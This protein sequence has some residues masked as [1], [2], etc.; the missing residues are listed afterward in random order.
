M[1]TR[2]C[3]LAALAAGALLLAACSP[4]PESAPAPAPEPAPQRI[5][6]TCADGYGFEAWFEPERVRV[7]FEGDSFTLPQVAAESGTTYRGEVASQGGTVLLRTKDRRGFLQV[8]GLRMENCEGTP[9]AD[10]WQSARVR[11]MELRAL[12]QEPGWWLELDRGRRTLVVTDY[13]RAVAEFPAPAGR[14][15][16]LLADLD[17]AATVHLARGGRALSLTVADRACRDVMSGAR[18][19]LTVRM[20]LDGVRYDGCGRRL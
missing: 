16:A 2:G 10:A 13:G 9:V 14:V 1:A 7:Q 4:P 8:P 12:G 15:D 11:G 17:G 20:R 5:A 19:P 3:G 6:F 18:H